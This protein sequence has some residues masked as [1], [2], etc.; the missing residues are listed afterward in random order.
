MMKTKLFLLVL[1][2]TINYSSAKPKDFLLEVENR[3]GHQKEESIFAEDQ[4][5]QD[6]RDYRMVMI[7]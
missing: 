6:D 2:L 1:S 4:D 5:G 3:E 7:L